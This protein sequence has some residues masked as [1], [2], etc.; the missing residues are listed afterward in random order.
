MGNLSFKQIDEQFYA[1]DVKFGMEYQKSQ[2]TFR[3]WSPVATAVAV[4]LYR[5]DVSENYSLICAGKGV[6]EVTVDGDFDGVLYRYVVTYENGTSREIID[7]WG[8]AS[9]ANGEYSAVVDLAKTTPINHDLRPKLK[10]ATDAIIYEVSVRDFTIHETASTN[11]KGKF[12]GLAELD[13]LKTLGVTHIQLLPIYDFEGVDELAPTES[14]N[15]GYNPSQYN[16]PEGSYATCPNDPYARINELKMLINEL[17]KQGFGVI[18]DVVYNHVYERNTHPF[19]AVVPNYF[20]RFDEAGVLTNSSGCG[21][22][23][24]SDRLMVR[25]YITDSVRFWLEEYGLDGFRFDLMGLLDIETMNQVRAICDRIDETILLYGEGWNIPM[26]LDEDKRATMFNADAMPKINHFNDFFRDT[27]KGST[28]DHEEQGLAF[29]N[30]EFIDKGMEALVA[31]NFSHPVQSINYIECHDNHTVWDRSKLSNPNTSDDE[32]RLRHRLATAMVIFAQGIPFIHGG[33]EFFRTKF[34]VENS[35]RDRDEINAIN[36][37]D[38]ETNADNIEMIR[39]FLAIRKAY[40]AFR[41]TTREQVNQHV[42]ITKHSGSVIEYQ[43]TG[44]DEIRVFFNLGTKQYN[45][46]DDFNGFDVIANETTAGLTALKSL[47]SELTLAPLS[48]TIIVK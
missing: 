6:W 32:L 3:F 28:F 19:E 24:A 8:V 38:A 34:G 10:Q 30:L 27:I 36:W 18:M 48:T 7:P 44:N 4:G 9:N 12:L 11:Y 15:W 26:A 35:Y 14:Y 17:H 1:P 43:L 40:N 41:L 5:P 22:D 39:G 45:I 16:V 2:T 31:N 42:T 33:Q 13:Y 47:T 21:N 25:K 29:G 23:V 20:Y 46:A 37:V